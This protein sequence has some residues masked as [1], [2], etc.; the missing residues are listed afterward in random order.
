MTGK[1]KDGLPVRTHPASARMRNGFSLVELLVVVGIILV[2]TTI[3]F[4]SVT[5]TMRV[6]RLNSTAAQ[7]TG[8]LQVARYTAIRANAMNPPL[9][10]RRIVQG[11]QNVVWVDVNNNGAPDATE[12]QYSFTNDIQI[13][14]TGAPN[15]ASM[16][17]PATIVSPGAIAFNARGTLSFGA[18]AGFGAGAPAVYV[19]IFHYANSPQDGFTAVSVTPFGKTQQWRASQN[20]VWQKR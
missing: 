8:T 1:L 11:N 4:P 12:P 10:W 17:Y 2:I 18:G 9:S 19:L 14:P 13:D 15:V 6:Y 7:V 5:R 3:A 16:G 20:G